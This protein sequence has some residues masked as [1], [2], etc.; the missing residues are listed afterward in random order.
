[1]LAVR[2]WERRLSTK[3]KSLLDPH[4]H[5]WTSEP[6]H[7][8]W[9][10]PAM[11]AA[12]T[13]LI[14]LPT[15]SYQFVWDDQMQVLTNPLVLSWSM[16]PRALETNLWFQIT[17]TGN[18]YRPF[19]IIWSIFAHSLFGFDPRGWHFLNVVLHVCA[20]VLVF[21]LLRQLRA[22]Y[23]TSV[24]ASLFSGF[25]PFTWNP[26]PGFRRGRIRSSQFLSCWPSWR[27]YVPVTANQRC[28]RCGSLPRW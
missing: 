9:G 13:F 23:W 21:I 12:L 17:T 24:V 4:P 20:T 26:Q 14:Y 2:F 3:E 27:T 8:R 19:F 15:L 11:V 1:M 18:F 7:Y 16:V 5:P 10:P 28:G 25:I 22:G 6:E